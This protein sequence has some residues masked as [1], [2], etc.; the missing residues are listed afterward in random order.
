MSADT[1][2]LTTTAFP[3]ALPTMTIDSSSELRA[4]L[5]TGLTLPAAWYS[6]P[7]VLRLE[8]ERIFKRAWQYAGT[9]ADVAEP[10]QFFAC[11]VGDVTVVV[12]RDRDLELRAFINVCRHRGHEIAKGCGRRETLQC[13]YHAWTYGLDGSLRSA[14]RSDR[15]PGFDLADWA[16]LPVLA[17]TWG[18]L[19]F[20]NPDV[21]AE[22]L[23]AVLGDLPRVAAERGLDPD[24][25]EFRGRSRELLIEANW[26]L[27]VENYLEC[28]HCPVAH[29]RFSRLIDVD[30]DSYALTTS[31]WTSSQFGPVLARVESWNARDLPYVPDGPIRSSQFHYVWP[32]WTLNTFPGRPTCACSCSS[33]TA[34][35]GR[36]RMSTASGLLERRTMWS[37]RSPSSALLS[38]TRISSSSSPCIEVSAQAWSLKG[39]FCLAA[40]ICCSTSSSSSTTCSPQAAKWERCLGSAV[41]RPSST[42]WKRQ[43]RQDLNLQ[44]PVLETGALPVELRPWVAP[45]V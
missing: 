45:R 34:L 32:N 7:A 11:R 24:T 9:A 41:G 8:Q 29:K 30:P 19:V 43:G 37:P 15:E 12:L 28:Y 16:L 39:G 4:Q 40:S 22:P 5:E 44:P 2:A 14:P 31:E 3:R 13:P 25:L 1:V 27:V 26:K 18:P 20:V 38:G 42:V 33:R 23:A 35:S 21:G 10:G 36:E 17:D 6:D